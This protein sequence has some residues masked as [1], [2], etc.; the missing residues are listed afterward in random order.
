MNKYIASLTSI[1]KTWFLSLSRIEQNQIKSS[2]LRTFA[3]PGAGINEV[4]VARTGPVVAV[5]PW[6]HAVALVAATPACPIAQSWPLCRWTPVITSLSTI[7]FNKYRKKIA[8]YE[9]TQFSMTCT[10]SD[11]LGAQIHSRNVLHLRRH[12]RSTH[13]IFV[14]RIIQ[15][16]SVPQHMQDPHASDDFELFYVW[17]YL[18]NLCS[19]I[20]HRPKCTNLDMKDV[21]KTVRSYMC[22]THQTVWTLWMHLC[23]DLHNLVCIRS[24][25]VD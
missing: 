6:R 20:S 2:Q 3:T 23:P 19:S 10:N 7:W 25:F 24:I 8:S 14:L 15:G 9:S 12:I 22:H 16:I 11:V 13:M 4:E 5:S 18:Q 1:K 17:F 21:S